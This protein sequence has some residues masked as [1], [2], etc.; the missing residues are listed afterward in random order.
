MQL[1]NLPFCQPFSQLEEFSNTDL[2]RHEGKG[3]TTVLGG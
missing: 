1:I 2:L 3:K